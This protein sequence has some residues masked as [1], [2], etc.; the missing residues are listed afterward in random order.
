LK[1][2]LGNLSEWEKEHKGFKRILVVTHGGYIMEF[3][4]VVKQIHGQKV[5]NSNNAKNCA[6]YIFGVDKKP[7]EVHETSEGN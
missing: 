5:T 6:V 2:I 1:K 7:K 4:N 3:Y